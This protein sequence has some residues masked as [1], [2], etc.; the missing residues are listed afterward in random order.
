MSGKRK[1]RLTQTPY[2]YCSLPP[3]IRG[4]RQPLSAP[5]YVAYRRGRCRVAGPSAFHV[6]A[7]RPEPP[8]TALAGPRPAC[9]GRGGVADF[10]VAREHAF[11]LRCTA[12]RRTAPT[13]TP[14]GRAR[15]SPRARP[16]D[17]AVAYRF[18]RPSPTPQGSRTP[19]RSRC[20]RRRRTLRT[21]GTWEPPSFWPSSAPSAAPSGL[22]APRAEGARPQG[23]GGADGAE[24]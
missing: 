3:G 13:S 21:S 24:A 1:V 9:A 5:R 17:T 8:P 19:P 16:D 23:R 20:R 12:G 10:T 2:Y 22:P 4:G 7:G 11:C 15:A 14:R 18:R 6:A